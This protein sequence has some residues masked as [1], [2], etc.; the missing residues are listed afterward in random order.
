MRPTRFGMLTKFSLFVKIFIAWIYTHVVHEPSQIQD[1]CSIPK[2]ESIVYLLASE[3]KYD[4]LF[5]NNLC[6]QNDMPLAYTG[7]GANKLRYCTLWRHFIGFFSKRKEQ[8][9]PEAIANAV[10]EHKP[11]LIFLN[12]YG[13]NERKNAIR[14]EAIFNAI[15]N[16]A[17]EHPELKIHFFP[18]G[19]IWERRAESDAHPLIHEI[20]GT[21]THP[22]SIRRF[23]SVHPGFLQLFLQIGQ[24]LCLIHHINLDF[25][26][27]HSASEIKQCLNDDID[28][29]HT[30]VNGPKVKPHQQLLNEI[31]KSEP[32]IKELQVI[33]CETGIAQEKLILDARKILD[34]TASKFSLLVCKMFCTAMAPMWKHIYTGLYIDTQKLNELRELSKTHRLVFIPSHK[35]HIDYLVLSIM[36]FL[37]GV[38]PPHIAAGENLN[39]P[40][41]GGILRRGGA[42]FIKRSFRG[43]QLYSACI[44]H[45][46][47]KILHEGY[48]IEFFIEGGRSRT[49]QVLQPKFG[50][51][52]MIAQAVEADPKLPVKIVPC[53]ITYEKVIEDMAYKKEQDGAAKKKENISGLLKTTKQLTSKYGQIYISFAPPIDFNQALTTNSN[54]PTVSSDDKLTQNIDKLAIELMAA[55]NKA[56]T[57]TTSSLLSCALLNI[58]TLPVSFNELLKHT[59]FFLALLIEHNATISPILETALAASRATRHEP[60]YSEEI[61]VIPELDASLNLN[62]TCLIPPLKKPLLEIIDIFEKSGSIRIRNRSKDTE[63]FDLEIIESGRLQMAFYKNILLFA[64]I[65][66]I[67][68]ACALLSLPEVNRTKE[69]VCERF[70]A[71]ADFFSIE[72]SPEDAQNRFEA[73]YESMNRR[74]WIRKEN[75]IITPAEAA[76]PALFKL[77]RCMATHIESYSAVFDFFD[78][79]TQTMEDADILS[80]IM[81]K[82]TEDILAHKKLPE[83]RSKVFYSHALTKLQNLKLYEA[84]YEQTG[85][86]HAKFLKKLNDLPEQLE[87]LV[88]DLSTLSSK[89]EP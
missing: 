18:V 52:R 9:S 81:K 47:S 17:L 40:P 57:I 82:A 87:K 37:H 49:G 48:P 65:D 34:K 7:N 23:V 30:Q 44:K 45:Y 3:N 58:E 80:Q 41:V 55:I 76:T 29:M 70:K 67:Y 46:I 63:N 4:F 85:K 50:I 35:S 42:F 84:S 71:I 15:R 53:A 89:L 88:T 14:T 8:P 19:I 73:A 79:Q 6:L 12:Q 25:N 11:V 32:F 33:S 74:L 10:L 83:S 60:Q 36:F 86:K 22:K 75:E 62:L 39:F 59:A 68:F 27:V 54:S 1:V 64:L 13:I 24:P 16:T 61:P 28:M 26:T 72:F 66:D 38:L 31:V 78:H 51:L 43:E 77:T 21:P 56:S 2:D 20:Y 69:N 5:L